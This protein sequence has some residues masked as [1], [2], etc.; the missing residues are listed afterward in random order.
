M[1]PIDP[2]KLYSTDEAAAAIG[3]TRVTIERACASGKLPAN[4]SPNGRRRRISGID[5]I[6]FDAERIIRGG[7]R[8]TRFLGQ[9]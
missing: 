7:R 5:L 6:L 2:T 1:D 3:V 4:M 8:S 9:A